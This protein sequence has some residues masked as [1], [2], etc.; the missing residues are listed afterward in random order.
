MLDMNKL[1]QKQ[2]FPFSCQT[3]SNM[4]Q[5]RILDAC[6]VQSAMTSTKVLVESA[7]RSHSGGLRRAICDDVDRFPSELST[8]LAFWSSKM[9]HAR[10]LDA[11]EAPNAL[12]STKIGVRCVRLGRGFVQLWG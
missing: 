1:S 7:P 4:H 2:R 11:W 12:T 5:A 10:I 3:G 8:T 9:H 6:D